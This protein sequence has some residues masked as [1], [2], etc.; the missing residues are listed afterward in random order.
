MHPIHGVHT[1]C[2]V[3]SNVRDRSNYGITWPQLL[4]QRFIDLCCVRHLTIFNADGAYWFGDLHFTTV[5][6]MF[7]ASCKSLLHLSV[8]PIQDDEDPDD[9][10]TFVSSIS[11]PLLSRAGAT[12]D[13]CPLRVCD[14]CKCMAFS[15]KCSIAEGKCHPHHHLCMDCDTVMRCKHCETLAHTGC[16]QQRVCGKNPYEWV[17]NDCNLLCGECKILTCRNHGESC[18]YCEQWFH[19]THC[20]KIHDPKCP[21]RPIP[22]EKAVLL[23]A[24]INKKKEDTRKKYGF[25]N[26]SSPAVQIEI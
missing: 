3:T 17:C 20:V 15:W 2:Y 12:V 23:T 21:K 10:K 8:D 14:N 22:K 19:D 13:G 6:V 11:T 1:F 9:Y 5:I 24:K 16:G 26:T 25:H 4:A 7:V 18:G